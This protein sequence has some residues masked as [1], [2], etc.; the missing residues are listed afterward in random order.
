MLANKIKQLRK[1]ANLSQ[2][3]LAEKLNVS[4]QAIAKWESGL[5]IPA[6]DNLIAIS[7]L[8]NISIDSLLEGSEENNNTN[9]FLY[10]SQMQYDIE[11]KKNYDIRFN[12]AKSV[13]IQAYDGEKILIRLA[14]NKINNIES[15]FKTKIKEVKRKIDVN[16]G[17]LKTITEDEAKESLE[18]FIILPQKFIKNIELSGKTEKLNINN[19]TMNTLEYTGYVKNIVLE[20]VFGHV[21]LDGKEDMTIICKNL[22]GALDINQISKAS[23][24]YLPEN[25]KFNASAKG[26]KNRIIYKKHNDIVESFAE[27]LEKLENSIN[28][29]GLKTE[30]IVEIDSS[31]SK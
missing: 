21:E 29:N 26:F 5:G 6:I 30:L 13:S 7:K 3:K 12:V 20:N 10:E 22:N 25:I 14:S 8:F 28:L 2:E 31:L 16:I 24:L 1:E 9:D 19:I 15:Y 4:R 27:D 23:K 17:Q 18:I 11:I